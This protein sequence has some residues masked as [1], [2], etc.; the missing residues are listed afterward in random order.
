MSAYDILEEVIGLKKRVKRL[1]VDNGIL[2]ALVELNKTNTEIAM[3]HLKEKS[4]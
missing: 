2:L 1:E 3:K 4:E